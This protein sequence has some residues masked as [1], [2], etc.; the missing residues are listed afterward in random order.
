VLARISPEDL[1]SISDSVSR[2]FSGSRGIS[3]SLASFIGDT[4]DKGTA[5]FVSLTENI[6]AILS[7]AVSRSRAITLRFA[8]ASPFSES[9]SASRLM[10]SVR[11][12]LDDFYFN[13]VMPTLARLARDQTRSGGS[14]SPL[15]FFI[16]LANRLA[17]GFEGLT[18]S[19]SGATAMVVAFGTIGAVAGVIALFFFRRRGSGCHV[20]TVAAP[21]C[22]RFGAEHKCVARGGHTGTHR[23]RCGASW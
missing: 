13:T 10:H 3:E 23:C 8:D 11:D 1:S 14:N 20:L 19:S 7:D 2:L 16:D 21:P 4:V 12:V 18:G 9:D 6:S 15:S 17:P 5:R 22:P